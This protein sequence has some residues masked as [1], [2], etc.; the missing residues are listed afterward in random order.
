MSETFYTDEDG[1]NIDVKTTLIRIR[2]TNNGKA[3]IV[4]ALTLQ[5]ICWIK[6]PLKVKKEKA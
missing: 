5:H 2:N 3:E 1:K 6:N 4:D